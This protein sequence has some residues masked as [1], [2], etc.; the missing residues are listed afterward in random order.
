MKYYLRPG[1]AEQLEIER[2]QVKKISKAITGKKT[3]PTSAVVKELKEKAMSYY[4]TCAF[5]KP[6]DKK[7]RKKVNGY[8]GKTDRICAYTGRPFAERHEIF[9]GRNRQISID[10]EF[11]ID[12][13]P[14]IHAELQANV[15]EW[16]Q[17]ENLRLR[18][19]CQSEYEGA[20]IDAGIAPDEARE[21]WLR[22]IGRS[23]L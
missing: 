9:C 17:A 16:A 4:N 7:K 23:Y 11:Q 15:T 14:E 18:Q 1:E 2:R 20:L 22:L 3:P 8:K 21:R 13:C 5:P 12:V 19:K 6:Q 10:N